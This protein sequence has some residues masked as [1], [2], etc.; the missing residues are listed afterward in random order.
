MKNIVLKDYVSDTLSNSSGFSLFCQ[1]EPLIKNNVKISIDLKGT[2][3]I[4]SSFFNSSFGSLIENMGYEKV[5]GS[6][7]FIN[8]TQTQ[9][10]ILSHLFNSYKNLSI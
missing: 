2:S 9:L 5:K 4:S 7:K 8:A 3:A 10:N 6:L 1:I